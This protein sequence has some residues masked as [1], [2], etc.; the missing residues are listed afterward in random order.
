[1]RFPAIIRWRRSAWLAGFLIFIH[2]GALVAVGYSLPNAAATAV[3]VA[4]IASSAAHSACVWRN[5][6]GELRLHDDGRCDFRPSSATEFVAME[7][8]WHGQWPGL[9][10]IGLRPEA[11]RR[12]RVLV[13]APGALSPGDARLLRLWLRCC[14]AGAAAGQDR[15]AA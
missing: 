7:L 10:S 14:A 2:L 11:Q 6:F 13:G 4:L 5:S 8:R 15:G 12:R 1:M 9:L 3:A